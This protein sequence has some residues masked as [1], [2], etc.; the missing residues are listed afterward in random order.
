MPSEPPSQFPDLIGSEPVPL[1]RVV[2]WWL[3][4]D[5]PGAPPA[6]HAKRIDGRLPEVARHSRL[7]R[8][9]SKE[10]AYHPLPPA[11][12]SAARQR[13]D[14]RARRSHAH[15]TSSRYA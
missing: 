15:F 6:R 9:R 5:L 11:T 1:E 13:T 12:C 10:D 4:F 3:L 8:A 7:S 2:R 14:P